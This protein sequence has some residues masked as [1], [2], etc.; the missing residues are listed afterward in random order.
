MQNANYSTMSSSINTPSSKAPAWVL[1]LSLAVFGWVAHAADVPP[2][3]PGLKYQEPLPPPPPLPAPT[4][5]TC[6]EKCE[7]VAQPCINRCFANKPKSGDKQVIEKCI[8]ACD[9]QQR[10]CY[11]QCADEIDRA[12]K[13][14]R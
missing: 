1:G 7:K 3:P 14:K 12:R 9:E 10:P 8:M 6:R 5:P 4:P 13:K 11:Q 2:P